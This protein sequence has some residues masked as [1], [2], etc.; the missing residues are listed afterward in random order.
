MIHTKCILCDRD[1]KKLTRNNLAMRQCHQ[2]SLVWRETFDVPIE[3]Y[4]SKEV[5]LSPHKVQARLA[6]CKERIAI[7]SRYIEMNNVCDIGCGEGL[8]LV[9]LKELGYH[10]SMGIEPSEVIEHFKNDNH[11]TI[12][13][14]TID[15]VCAL[16]KGKGV[17]V[18]TM[19]HLIEHLADPI[20][21]LRALKGCMAN[22]DHLMI[23]TPDIDSY[24]FKISDYKNPLVYPEHLFY[25]NRPNLKKLLDQCG[26]HAITWGKRGFNQKNMSIR[27]SLQRLGV[28]T[29]HQVAKDPEARTEDQTKPHSGAAM[30]REA[31]GIQKYL[32][33]FVRKALNILVVMLQRTDYQW[34]IAKKV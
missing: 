24:I 30:A 28:M 33:N 17:R 12:Y 22:G 11:L 31:T 5:N 7:A 25:F 9:A 14:G 20:R 21:A 8:F 29:Y 34:I 27:E 6:N 23:E 16:V 1:G 3:H 13:K 4:E 18:F 2:C 19:F 10:H 32:V 26:F 15:D